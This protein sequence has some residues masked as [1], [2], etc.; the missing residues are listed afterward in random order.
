MRF[1]IQSAVEHRQLAETSRGGTKQYV[2]GRLAAW[3]Q[4]KWPRKYDDLPAI[5]EVNAGRMAGTLSGYRFK[6]SGFQIPGTLVECQAQLQQAMLRITTLEQD[7]IVAREDADRLRPDAEKW[8]DYCA[9]NRAS[10]RR[11]RTR[12]NR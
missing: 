11:P 10:A 1:H 2:F 8:R 12:G 9:T 3:A 6:A 7:V 4:D 5:R